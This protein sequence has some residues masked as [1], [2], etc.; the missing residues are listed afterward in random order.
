MP[1]HKRN[2]A[3]FPEGLFSMDVTEIPG[4]DN[5]LDPRGIIA[6]LQDRLAR[7]NGSGASYITTNGSTGGVLAA[8]TAVAGRVEA[9]GEIII[10]RNC[11]KSVY[12]A[13]SI[14][15]LTPVY[16]YPQITDIHVAGGVDPEDVRAA[17]RLY[18]NAAAVVLTSPTYE[19]FVSDIKAIVEIAHQYKTPVIVDEAH[20]AHFCFSDRFPITSNLCGADIVVQSLHKQLPIMSQ[21]AVVHVNGN[22]VPGEKVKASLNIFQ[23]TSPSYVLLAQADYALNLL[24]GYPGIIGRYIEALE[25]F[26]G[27]FPRNLDLSLIG[28]EYRR[29]NSIYAID[30]AKLV[31]Y[32]KNGCLGEEIERHILEYKIQLEMSGAAHAVALTTCADTAEGFSRLVSAAKTFV[33]TPKKVF[34]ETVET[35]RDMPK[36]EVVMPPREAIMGSSTPRSLEDSVG[37]VSAGF[38]IPYP[39]GIPLVAPG[40][41]ITPE[42]VG[43]IRQN[44]TRVI[45][46]DMIL[47]LD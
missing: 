42:V 18:P 15:N 17:L 31:F 3:F 37:M 6:D 24:E 29:K 43:F 4:A 25:S 20:G 5:L 36:A 46:A 41:R 40:E 22:L 28:C 33:G 7:A 14:N 35:M 16:I 10:A 47:T 45:G 2:P 11:H 19:G 26:R 1:G 27:G 39:P 32:S 30:P 9:G 44:P 8:V 21:M 34:A 12:S 38:V 13:L 23:T